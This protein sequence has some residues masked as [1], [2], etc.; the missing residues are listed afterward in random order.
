MHSFLSSFLFL[1]Q[2]RRVKRVPSS[3]FRKPR[4]FTRPRRGAM[5]EV[6]SSQPIFVPAVISRRLARGDSAL[7]AYFQKY[8]L[9]PAAGSHGRL[10][11]LV[12]RCIVPAVG[13]CAANFKIWQ[14]AG[15]LL[16]KTG[17]ID[18]R[19][20]FCRKGKKLQKQEEKEGALFVYT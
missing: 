14:G 4:R 6:Y 12:S 9:L 1:T 5:Y 19:A 18:R 10:N 11:T 13:R 15:L 20:C 16:C 2:T 17:M 7:P 3:E 8:L